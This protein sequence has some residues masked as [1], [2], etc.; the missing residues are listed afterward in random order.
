MEL[1]A[2]VFAVLS[3]VQHDIAEDVVRL[4]GAGR[5]LGVV[6]IVENLA[7]AAEKTIDA[8]GH[9]DRKCLHPPGQRCLA[10]CFD[11]QVQVIALH[12]KLAN[13]KVSTHCISFAAMNKGAMQNLVHIAPT[14]RTQTSIA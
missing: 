11:D 7:P 6:A 9:S 13:T 10:V 14:K 3:G 1:L 2:G 12:G 5:D 4:T 8:F